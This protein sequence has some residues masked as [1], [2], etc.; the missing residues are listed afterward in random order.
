[1]GGEG[2]AGGEMREFESCIRRVA[3]GWIVKHGL[4]EQTFIFSDLEDALACVANEV[5]VY[6]FGKR[7][8]KVVIEKEEK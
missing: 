8:E 5:C 4:P 7:I 6:E 1:M 3:N 2:G